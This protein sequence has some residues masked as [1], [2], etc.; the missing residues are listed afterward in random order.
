MGIA[1]YYTH[2]HKIYEV[3]KSEFMQRFPYGYATFAQSKLYPTSLGVFSVTRFI[4]VPSR[5]V[6]IHTKVKIANP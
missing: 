2:T 4:N 5:F 1:V 3:F 6:T